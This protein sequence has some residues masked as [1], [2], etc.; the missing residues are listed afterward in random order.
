MT[1]FSLTQIKPRAI[2]ILIAVAAIILVA[3]IALILTPKKKTP[4]QADFIPSIPPSVQP[5]P[6]PSQFQD[7]LNKIIDVLPYKTSTYTI[8]Y[9]KP[10]NLITVIVRASS[11]NEYISTK[12]DAETF[13]KSKGVKDICNLNIIWSPQ[14]SSEIRKSLSPQEVRTTGCPSFRK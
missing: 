3:I 11:K 2:I 7:E 14:T 10:G 8:E 5:V 12:S 6:Q 13:I 9:F 4:K 1:N